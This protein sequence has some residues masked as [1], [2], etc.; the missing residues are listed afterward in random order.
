MPVKTET[1]TE[2]YITPEELAERLSVSRRRIWD[3]ASAGKIPGLKICRQWRFLL[4]DVL[5][6]LE[7]GNSNGKKH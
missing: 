3:L 4:S 2:S 6:A 5:T 1:P 7:N